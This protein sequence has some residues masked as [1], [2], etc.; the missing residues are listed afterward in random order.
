MRAGFLKIFLVVTAVGGVEL[1]AATFTLTP[2]ADTS[3]F[4]GAAD[5]NMGA[6]ETIAAGG[7]AVGVTFRALLKFDVAG[8][9]PPDATV[10]SASLQ[11]TVI[12]SA[13]A[14]SPSTF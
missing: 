12:K 3:L 14:A 2:V 8:N 4:E 13:G 1:T 11:L 6:H 9:L 7:N 10:Q 5:N